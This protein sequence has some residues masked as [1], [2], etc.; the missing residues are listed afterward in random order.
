MP[1]QMANVAAIIAICRNSR[2]LYMVDIQTKLLAKATCLPFSVI[3]EKSDTSRLNQGY[4]K[5]L[6]RYESRMPSMAIVTT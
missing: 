4:N 2:M 6:H 5:L 3:D 1:R